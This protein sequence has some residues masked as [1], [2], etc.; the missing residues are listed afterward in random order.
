MNNDRH[1][2]FARKFMSKI[3]GEAVR[4][5]NGYGT[6]MTLGES[7]LLGILLTGERCFGV[8]RHVTVEILDAMINRV[9]ERLAA[10][11][12]GGISEKKS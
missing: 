10:Q 6:I 8:Q 9:L 3:I 1:N 2:F 4:E 11:P 5:G 7:C 12:V